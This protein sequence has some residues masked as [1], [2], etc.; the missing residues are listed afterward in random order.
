MTTLTPRIIKTESDY[1][2]ALAH[3]A[4]LMDAAP[5]SAA[6][7]ELEVWAL[8]V[9]KYE[10]TRF[11]IPAPDPISAIKFRME[12]LGLSRADLERF[13][14]NKSKV[15]EVLSRRRPL[16]LPMI[17]KLHRGLRI[18]AEVLVQPM[19]LAS[20]SRSQARS[21]RRRKAALR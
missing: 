4:T 15:S 9:E 3:V 19:R 1:E 7:A 13:I 8:L 20:A 17:Q 5:G 12:Q 10:E 14:P 6:E 16:S 2:T 11:P 21:T 18:P